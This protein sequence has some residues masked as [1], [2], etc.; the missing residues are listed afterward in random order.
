MS[1]TREL[2]TKSA[3]RIVIYDVL[4]QIKGGKSLADALSAHLKQ[5]SGLYVSMVRAGEAGGVLE[6]ILARLADFEPM[7][8]PAVYLLPSPI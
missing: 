3:L 2:L 6:L 7:R 8:L 1:I 4:T 5:F